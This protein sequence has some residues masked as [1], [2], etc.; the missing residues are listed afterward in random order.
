MQPNTFLVCVCVSV[1]IMFDCRKVCFSSDLTHN[2]LSK[3]I[4]IPPWSYNQPFPI[5]RHY[6]GLLRSAQACFKDVHYK[7]ADDKSDH[8]TPCFTSYYTAQYKTEA[9]HTHT[10]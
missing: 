10:L 2:K 5:S 8:L 9:T 6:T 3:R 1:C 7:P 4:P